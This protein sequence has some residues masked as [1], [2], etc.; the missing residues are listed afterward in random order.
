[1]KN[2]SVPFGK[3][4]FTPLIFKSIGVWNYNNFEFNC[5]KTLNLHSTIQNHDIAL[6]IF[7]L[8]E[9]RLVKN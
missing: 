8:I 6:E 1:M 9:K 3:G 4:F 2:K 5:Q 7:E